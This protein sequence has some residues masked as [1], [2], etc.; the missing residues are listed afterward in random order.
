[1]CQVQQHHAHVFE[2][3]SADAQIRWVSKNP[4]NNKVTNSGSQP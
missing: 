4:K 1:M 2:Q 3:K